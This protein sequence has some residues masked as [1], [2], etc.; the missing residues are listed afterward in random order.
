[1]LSVYLAGM[2]STI[3]IRKAQAAELRAVGIE[4]T[5]RWI[6]ETVPHNAET[7]DVPEKYLKETA[8]ADI[9]DIDDADIF[10]AFVPTAEELIAATVTASSRGGRHVEFGYA[11][12]TGKPIFVVGH[13]EN[14]FHYY[15]YLAFGQSHFETF[16][17]ALVAIKLL[18]LEEI[19]INGR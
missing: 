10:L 8:I 11:L 3:K 19:E 6:D 12:G 4:V 16:R 13:K 18:Q 17:E 15:P 14:V 2:F 9:E 1:M 7:K 5:S